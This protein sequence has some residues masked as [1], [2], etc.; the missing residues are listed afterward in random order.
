MKWTLNVCLLKNI[1]S[2]ER[3]IMMKIHMNAHNQILSLLRSL[4]GSLFFLCIA[5]QAIGSL[6]GVFEQYSTYDNIFEFLFNIE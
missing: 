2:V 5:D 1:K 3:N 6:N 4:L